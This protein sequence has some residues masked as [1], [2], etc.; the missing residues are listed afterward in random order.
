VQ[1]FVDG[2]VA[3]GLAEYISHRMLAFEMKDINGESNIL[4][5]GVVLDVFCKRAIVVKE[6]VI[7]FL[8]VNA[9][10]TFNELLIARH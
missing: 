1:F 8:V 5:E 7:R 4:E 2:R 9:E 6:D 10:C 3:V